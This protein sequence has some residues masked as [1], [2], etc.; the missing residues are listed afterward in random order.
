MKR[1]IR[2]A[3]VQI[4][5]SGARHYAYYRRGGKRVRLRSDADDVE[6]LRREIADIHGQRTVIMARHYSAHAELPK[7]TR[8]KVLKLQFKGK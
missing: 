4:Y 7:A 8:A 5:R 3:Y 2:I 1:T 6:G